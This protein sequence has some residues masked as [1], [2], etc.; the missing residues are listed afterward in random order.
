MP[1]SF[2]VATGSDRPAIERLVLDAFEPITWQKKLDARFGPLNGRD[3]Q[4]RWQ[5]RLAKIFE[6]QIVL[7]G[8]AS[9]NLAAVATG[10]VDSE[11]ALGFIDVLAVG[12]DFQ[13]KGYGREM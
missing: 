6:A 3:W 13:G 12:R 7:V 1:L 10:T 4:D 5:R 8:E 9:G 11:A 2:R